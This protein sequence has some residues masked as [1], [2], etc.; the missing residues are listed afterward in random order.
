MRT[1]LI[2]G[3]DASQT[4]IDSSDGFEVKKTDEH[5]SNND[6]NFDSTSQGQEAKTYS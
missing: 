1:R 6:L 5:R 2:N 4:V 3:Q